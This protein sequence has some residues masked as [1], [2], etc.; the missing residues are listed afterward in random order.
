MTFEEA[1]EKKKEF[2]NSYTDKEKGFVEY[3]ILITPK[4]NKD[5]E[6]YFADRYKNSQSFNQITIVDNDAKKYSTDNQY[7]IHAIKVIGT[8]LTKKKLA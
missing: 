4:N 8:I 1:V 3:G 6:V 5:L 2:G 7:S